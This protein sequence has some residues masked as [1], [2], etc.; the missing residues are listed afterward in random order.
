M[1]CLPCGQQSQSIRFVIESHNRTEQAF[2]VDKTG[3]IKLERTLDYET[4]MT[5]QFVVWVTDGLTVRFP[6]FIFQI[7]EDFTNKFMGRTILRR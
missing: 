6:S 2:S 7:D 1:S 3:E 4:Q 5:H